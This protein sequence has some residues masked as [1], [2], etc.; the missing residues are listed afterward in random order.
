LP[1]FFKVCVVINEIEISIISDA[2]KFITK[3]VMKEYPLVK[4]I[5]VMINVKK[6][7]IILMIVDFKNLFID[8][9]NVSIELNI[10]KIKVSA[11]IK[12][13][14]LNEK[15]NLLLVQKLYKNSPNISEINK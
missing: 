9:I 11:T 13:K 4:R 8:F 1:Y 7:I 10:L 14:R 3:Y 5:Y 12:N 15:S 6:D 2:I